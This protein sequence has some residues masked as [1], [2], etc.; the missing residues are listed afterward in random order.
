VAAGYWLAKITIKNRILPNGPGFPAVR[1]GSSPADP[2][3]DLTV[4]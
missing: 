1:A 3:D 2:V 4:R